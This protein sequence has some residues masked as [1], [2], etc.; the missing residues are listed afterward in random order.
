MPTVAGSDSAAKYRRGM[1]PMERMRYIAQ[2]HDVDEQILVPEVAG[3][4]LDTVG[5][6]IEMVAAAR[7]VLA[8]QPRCAPLVWLCAHMLV[9][10]DPADAAEDCVRQLDRRPASNALV[11]ALDDSA[12]VLVVGDAMLTGEALLRRPDVHASVL[13]TS[14]SGHRLM[15]RLDRPAEPADVFELELLSVALSRVELVVVEPMMVDGTRGV[16]AL[17][18]VAAVSVASDRSIPVW[19]TIGTGR[20]M[21]EPL[22]NAAI[23]RLGGSVDDPHGD[24]ETMPNDRIDRFVGA[25]GV[26]EVPAIDTPLA[27]E[28][29]A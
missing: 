21:P 28:L 16:Y 13:T 4:L 19:A 5:E 10:L 22:F 18:S 1:H 8:H 17:G 25:A 11:D 27:A 7:R 2:A 9:A 3:M 24:L 6:P 12:S 23:G 20:S 14:M 29:G 15:H 26:S